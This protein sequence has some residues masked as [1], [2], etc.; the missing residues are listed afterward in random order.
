MHH[1][2]KPC[3]SLCTMPCVS[4]RRRIA[5]T[6]RVTPAPEP[7]AEPRIVRSAPYVE[8]L[9]YTRSQAAEA[10]GVSRS[11]FIRRVL[12]YV[13][14]IEMPWGAK[15][16]PVDELERLVAERRKVAHPPPEPTPPGRPPAVPKD[17]VL[18]IQ[19]EHAAG[20]SLRQIA[21]A[22]NQDGVATAHGGVRWWPSTVR[23][24]LERSTP[25]TSARGGGGKR[26]AD[27][28]PEVSA[29][30]PRWT[31][32]RAPPAGAESC[33]CRHRTEVSTMLEL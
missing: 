26:S 22:L 24:V 4:R 2:A 6:R 30:F 28:L 5:R 9:A 1:D 12:P 19:A 14:T 18:R 31:P 20:T 21:A 27:Q 8:R 25:S 3:R 33:P 7:T 11:T 29:T 13:D 15:L 16:I 17:V 10:L 32:R 23:S